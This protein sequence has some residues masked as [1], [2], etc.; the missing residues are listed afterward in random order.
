MSGSFYGKFGD[1]G[2]N[3]SNNP[4]NVGKA[5]YDP[6]NISKKLKEL[7]KGNKIQIK[8]DEI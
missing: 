8:R 6:I 7:G 1:Y 4:I 2:V 5:N 3:R